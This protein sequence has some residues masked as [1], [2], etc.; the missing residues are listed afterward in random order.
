MIT[1]KIIEQVVELVG[2]N[3]ERKTVMLS[4]TNILKIVGL[5]GVTVGID[6]PE[7][8][9]TENGGWEVTVTAVGMHKDTNLSITS[10]VRG[11]VHSDEDLVKLQMQ[12][13]QTAVLDIMENIHTGLF[14]G[15]QSM[16]SLIAKTMYGN[17]VPKLLS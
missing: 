10:K 6:P 1:P 4:Y 15:I 3:H 12:A 17:T 2:F 13:G 7:K 16:V 9:D 14:H 11:P 8:V 5:F